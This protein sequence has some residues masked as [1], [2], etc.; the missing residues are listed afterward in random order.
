MTEMLSPG[1]YIEELDQSQIVPSNSNS[2]AVFSGKFNMG[3]TG[4]FTL[5]TDVNDL[6]AN[7]GYPDDLN[8][9]DWYQAWNFLQYGNKLLISRAVDQNGTTEFLECL[10]IATTDSDGSDFEKN[11]IY[12]TKLIQVGLVI[13]FEKQTDDLYLVVAS[14]RVDGGIFM[15]TLDRDINAD[16]MPEIDEKIDQLSRTINGLI[17]MGDETCVET[18]EVITDD[19]DEEKRFYDIYKPTVEN[20]FEYFN[21]N[22]FIGNNTEFEAKRLDIIFTNPATSKLKIISRNPGIWAEDLEICIVKPESFYTNSKDPTTHVSKFAFDGILVD[23]LF[24]YAPIDTEFGIVI[25][26]KGEIVEKHTV[27]IDKLSK[28]SQNKSIYIENV[29][30][31]KS[32]YIYIKDNQACISVSDTTMFYDAQSKTYIGSPLK[33]LYST[34]SSIQKDDLI[35]GYGIFENKEET[36]VD[37]VIANELD[38]GKSGQNVTIVRKD[39]IAFIGATYE[40]CVGCTNSIATLNL[41]DWRMTG[42]VSQ[43]S[44]FSAVFGNYKYQ[45]DS[46]NDVYRW[47]NLAGDIAGLRAET[48]MN[49]ASWWASAGLERGKIKNAQKLAF[50]PTKPMRD[51]LYK[52][53]I[54]PCVTFPGMGSVCWGQKTLLSKATSFDRISVRGLFNTIERSLEEMSRYQIM[55]FNDTFTRNRIISMIKPYLSGVQAGRGI[56]DFLV[57]CDES[58]NTPN[59]IAHNELVVDVYIKPNYVAEFIKLRF[60]N[61]GTNSFSSIVS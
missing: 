61:V 50:N 41:I 40:D 25:R 9:N 48:T 38:G 32:K 37:I 22:M 29:I 33:L 53:A 11:Q 36:S 6:I 18:V 16:N 8:Y 24:E 5:N 59:V 46:Y 58:N 43:D 49:R 7:H 21:A 17:E 26:Y 39:S 1:V 15:L 13:Q 2:I 4:V 51:L 60:T 57:I 10:V 3:S 52:N 34:S 35:N 31:T 20:D 12:V 14:E 42:D 44:M 27:D 55:E 54:N 19:N 28:N 45:Y 56:Q 47:I 30:N 23:D